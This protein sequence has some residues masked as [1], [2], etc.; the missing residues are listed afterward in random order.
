MSRKQVEWSFNSF[1]SNLI[2]RTRS[3]TWRGCCLCLGIWAAMYCF[4]TTCLPHPD[5]TPSNWVS[6][7]CPQCGLKEPSTN[8][9]CKTPGLLRFQNVPSLFFFCCRS[10]VTPLKTRHLQMARQDCDLWVYSYGSRMNSHNFIPVVWFLIVSLSFLRLY[11]HCGTMWFLKSSTL[12]DAPAPTFEALDDLCDPPDEV[13]GCD[14]VMNLVLVAILNVVVVVV[15]VV[16]L[17]LL[18]VVV[19]VVVAVV[20][21]VVLVVTVALMLNATA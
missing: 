1:P 16:V 19:V 4:F 7:W 15:V 5:P 3:G 10:G 14:G 9:S 18:V 17:A 21:L 8:R 11:C 13:C 2:F 12:R 6:H 20:V